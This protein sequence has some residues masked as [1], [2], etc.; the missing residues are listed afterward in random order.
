MKM[1]PLVPECLNA[2]AVKTT[3]ILVSILVRCLLIIGVS[4]YLS[5]LDLNYDT[6]IKF[7]LAA[8]GPSCQHRWFRKRGADIACRDA[9]AS[10]SGCNSCRNQGKTACRCAAEPSIWKLAWWGRSLP[11]VM[12]AGHILVSRRG[13]DKRP[14][15][16]ALKPFGLE[17]EI[18][19][20]VGDFST[21]LA[22]AQDSDL[23]IATVPERHTRKPARRNVAIAFFF[24]YF[25]F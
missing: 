5:L 3:T 2:L 22:L 1:S 18:V 16:E 25:G 24:L 21:A 15:D 11:P 20:I 7:F 8:S 14:I 9:S 17:R 12:R 19:T 4:I 10:A 13:L 23:M 6:F